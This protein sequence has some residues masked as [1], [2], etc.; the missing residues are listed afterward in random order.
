[1]LCWAFH[2]NNFIQEIRKEPRYFIGTGSMNLHNDIPFDFSLNFDWIITKNKIIKQTD[3]P[4]YIYSHTDFLPFFVKNILNLLN[5]DFVLIT[6]CSDY[7]PSINFKN[8]YN[9]IINNPF[10]K[11][12]YSQNTLSENYKCMSLPAGICCY[13]SI[14]DYKLQNLY[15]DLTLFDNPRKTKILCI[16]N[17]RYSNDCGEKYIERPYFTEFIKKY[18][19]IFDFFEANLNSDDFLELLTKYTHILLPLGNGADLCPKLLEALCC[20]TIPIHLKNNNIVNLKKQINIPSIMLNNLDEILSKDFFT[21]NHID[22]KNNY[23]ENIFN[24]SA[25]FWANK[26]KNT[27]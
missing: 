4:K 24:F 3:T 16:W 14:H 27:N 6:G 26:I 1:M 13:S 20:K 23:F 21:K 7:S 11:Y 17:M 19:E 25:E 18:P 15:N 10:L 9:I 5:N 22:L 12:W 2:D 8:E